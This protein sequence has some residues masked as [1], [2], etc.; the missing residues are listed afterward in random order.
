MLAKV[1]SAAVVG[2]EARLVEVQVDAAAG[3]PQT[4]TLGLPDNAIRESAERVRTAI[5]NS[6]F[7]FPPRRITVN[8]APAY[9]PKAGSGFPWRSE[10]SRRFAP[11]PPSDNSPL[12]GQPGGVETPDLSDSRPGGRAPCAGD[13]R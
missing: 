7:E 3:L 6:G 11:R 2:I 9:L 10:S 5:L 13:R 12:S 8:L 4:R 1:L